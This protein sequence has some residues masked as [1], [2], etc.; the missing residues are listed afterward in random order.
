MVYLNLFDR[1]VGGGGCTLDKQHSYYTLMMYVLM[2]T[3]YIIMHIDMYTSYN[4]NCILYEM[5]FAI[6]LNCSVHL[7]TVYCLTYVVH[8]YKLASAL[9]PICC[10]TALTKSSALTQCVKLGFTTVAS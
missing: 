9:V 4:N 8:S 5:L 1:V 7:T 2:L 6:N 10:F 3:H